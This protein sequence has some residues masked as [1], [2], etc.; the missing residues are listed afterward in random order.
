MVKVTAAAATIRT[1]TVAASTVMQV[2]SPLTS[3]SRRALKAP[4]RAGRAGIGGLGWIGIGWLTST[5]EPEKSPLHYGSPE[6]SVSCLLRCARQER[7]HEHDEAGRQPD[8]F[9]GNDG[10]HGCTHNRLRESNALSFSVPST[11]YGSIS[12]AYC[13]NKKTP[14]AVIVGLSH[15]KSGR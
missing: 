5:Q 7:G 1:A 12:P 4:R 10:N 15:R 3:Q 8:D 13:R 6:P 9:D 2:A 14:A 11:R